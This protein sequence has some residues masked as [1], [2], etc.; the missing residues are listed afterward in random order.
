MKTRLCNNE[1]EHAACKVLNWLQNFV[2]P[3]AMKIV[4]KIICMPV[5]VSIQCCNVSVQSLDFIPS[6]LHSYSYNIGKK[7]KREGTAG[8]S[9]SAFH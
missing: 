4:Q 2:G 7:D 5:R 1:F 3:N 9:R 6:F 8:V